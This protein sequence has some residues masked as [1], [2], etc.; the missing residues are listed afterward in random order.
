MIRQW[1]DPCLLC[2]CTPYLPEEMM[3][4]M[5]TGKRLLEVL[6]NY[7][8]AGIG[9]AAPQIGVT[10]RVFA[11]D[12]KYLKIKGAPIFINPTIMW[13]SADTEEENEGCL[14]FPQDFVVSVRRPVSISLCYDTPER[15]GVMVEL[16]GLAARAACHEVEHLQGITIA[17]RLT[18][19]QHRKLER[20]VKQ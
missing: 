10:R 19:Q 4:A 7:K 15:E 2:E 8:R 12:I 14:S 6:A 13:E 18:R 1:A 9:L 11:L 20:A 16:H 3:S 17:T 5:E